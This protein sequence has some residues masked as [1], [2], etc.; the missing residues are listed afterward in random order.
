MGVWFSIH[1]NGFHHILK[2]LL[3]PQKVRA[4]ALDDEC[5]AKYQQ[6]KGIESAPS[7][8]SVAGYH[9]SLKQSNGVHT[10]HA[11]STSPPQF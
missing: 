10:A 5:E 11:T 4:N 3:K 1:H 9:Q 6:T 7:V 2:E 8:C